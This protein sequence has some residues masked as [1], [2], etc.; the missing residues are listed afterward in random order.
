MKFLLSL[1]L[2]FVCFAQT[3]PVLALPAGDFARVNSLDDPPAPAASPDPE[4]DEA[5]RRTALAEERKKKAE[6]EAAE[7]EAKREKL[8]AQTDAFGDPSKVSV[9]TGG[10]QTDQEGFVEV[11]MLSLEA[12]RNITQRLAHVLCNRA[13]GE[14]RTL[15]IY[16]EAEL[17]AIA[18]YRAMLTQLN[19]FHQE[20]AAREKAFAALIVETNPQTRSAESTAGGGPT[21]ASDAS[22]GFPLGILAAPGIATG[23]VT[24][25]AQLI[26]LFR[27][28]TS[29]QNKNVAIPEDM[30]VSYLVSNLQRGDIACKN[31]PAIYYPQ[32][33]PARLFQDNS[34][35][36]FLTLLKTVAFD[37][38]TAA[39]NVKTIEARIKL[40]NQIA[41]LIEE[42]DG[43]KETVALKQKTRALLLQN[44]RCRTAACHR[45]T[46]EIAALKPQIDTATETIKKATGDNQAGF[47]A[48]HKAWLKDLKRLQTVTQFLIDSA[49][50]VITKLET[51]DETT[52]MPPLTQVLSAEQLEGILK[53]NSTFM[54][55][56]AVTANGTT[57]IKKNMFVDA[58]VRHSAGANLVFQLFDHEGRVVDGDAMQFYFDYKSAAAVRDEVAN[59]QQD[60]RKPDAAP[61]DT[62]S[63]VPKKQ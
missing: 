18:V 3:V 55:R 30:V 36:P 53:D 35:S 63:A 24:S 44:R 58:K 48:K 14:V 57:K 37:K 52:K 7:A 50:D 31:E 8:K 40:I 22:G 45:V 41:G 32:L 56:V 16:N 15:V 59:A 51:P 47:E 29:F 60:K 34:K 17:K 5:K 13:G 4:M 10:V 12:A 42:R 20:F 33:Y 19:Q 39:R 23:M 25:I 28:D 6:A 62:A 21:G 46:A 49:E 43:M 38:T 1:A 27:T 9:P 26:N 11:K 54:L 61:T 2:S